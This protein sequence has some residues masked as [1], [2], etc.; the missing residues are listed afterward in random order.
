M[1]NMIPNRMVST[2]KAESKVPIEM[3]KAVMMA[4]QIVSSSTEFCGTPN[5]FF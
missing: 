4:G 2:E 1:N 3:P 5:L